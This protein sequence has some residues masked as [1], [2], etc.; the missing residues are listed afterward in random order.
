M[1]EDDPISFIE[2]HSFHIPEMKVVALVHL[3]NGDVI[4]AVV[5]VFLMKHP[6]WLLYANEHC[7]HLLF[8]DPH[9]DGVGGYDTLDEYGVSAILDC[10]LF[11]GLPHFCTFF[12]FFFFCFCFLIH[13]F[14]FI[15]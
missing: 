8:E 2:S 9:H 12:F 4:T 6:A 3:F 14:Q 10:R 7:S 11:E 1:E 15:L 5:D 13:F